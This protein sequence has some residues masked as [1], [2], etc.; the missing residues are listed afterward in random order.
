MNNKDDVIEE[1]A[2]MGVGDSSGEIAAAKS[3]PQ[4][5]NK[6]DKLSNVNSILI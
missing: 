4:R 2:S 1:D 3:G 5:A 6:N